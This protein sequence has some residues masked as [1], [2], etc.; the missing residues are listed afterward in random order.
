MLTLKQ[1]QA[2]YWVH[3][4]GGY[5]TAA[6]HL[7]ATQSAISKR[8]LELEETLGVK[9]FEP[10]NR[11]QLTLKGREILGDLEK[12]L[13]LQRNIVLRVSDEAMYSGH[14]RLGVSEMVALT[15]L[16]A[17]V[18]AVKETF[19]RLV[20]SPSVNLTS[21]LW[22]QM[23]N[24]RLDMIICPMM[25]EEPLNFSSSVLKVMSARWMCKPGLLRGPDSSGR[26]SLKDIQR[27]PLLTHSEGSRLYLEI[28]HL[29]QQAGVRFEK[30]IHC[31]SVIALAELATA[32]LGVTCL[33]EEYFN[34]YVQHGDLQ[35]FQ[36]SLGPAE[37]EFRAIHRSDIVSQRIAEIAHSVCDFRH[38]RGLYPRRAD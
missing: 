2:V 25:D 19:P 4:L 34:T 7:H 28:A 18:A 11:T 8:V 27:Q 36:C 1:I 37:L 5:H 29:L 35:T 17:L 13:E 12:I 20:L 14:F 38:P 15:W 22:N 16:P 31:N 3:V 6:D 21:V 32:G 26:H 23:R 24:Q 9:V 33:P 30:S 10:L